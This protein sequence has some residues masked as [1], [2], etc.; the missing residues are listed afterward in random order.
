[1]K[2]IL[3]LKRNYQYLL[4]FTFLCLV[5]FTTWYLF[6]HLKVV[7]EVPLQITGIL[8]TLGFG[9]ALFQFGFKHIT[10]ERRRTFDLRYAAYKEVIMLVETITE[11][12]NEELT[13]TKIL[14]VNDLL[15]KLTNQINRL[16]STLNEYNY[17]L[18][19]KIT[20]TQESKKLE[21]TTKKIIIRTD[22]YRAAVEKAISIGNVEKNNFLETLEAMNWHNDVLK[23][24]QELHQNKDKFYAKLREY[25]K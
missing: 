24:L 15:A 19:L 23:Y 18:F 9:F 20:S 14:E 17:Y 5:I 11:T 13:A 6:F 12:I 7:E 8:S 10:A 25:L 1:M 21:E 4:V 16:S 22:K 3:Y 2:V